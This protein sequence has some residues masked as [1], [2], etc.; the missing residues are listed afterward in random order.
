M[1]HQPGGDA[2]SKVP[3]TSARLALVRRLARPDALPLLIDALPDPR[4]VAM[5]K[6]WRRVHFPDVPIHEL[7]DRDAD[8]HP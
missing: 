4:A 7:P 3:Q 1:N 6:A 2:E 8:G 5:L